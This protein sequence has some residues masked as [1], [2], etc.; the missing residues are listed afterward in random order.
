MKNKE[1]KTLKEQNKLIKELV[2]AL[3]EVRDGKTIPF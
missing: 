2:L 1:L 3:H